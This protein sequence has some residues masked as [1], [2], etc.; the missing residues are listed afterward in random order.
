MAQRY[1]K[2][3]YPLAKTH[4]ANVTKSGITSN[5]KGLWWRAIYQSQT[6]C[7]GANGMSGRS[8]KRHYY[9]TPLN[10]WFSA[11][12]NFNPNR[13]TDVPELSEAYKN[14]FTFNKSRMGESR[15]SKHIQ[16]ILSVF[17]KWFVIKTL[18]IPEKLHECLRFAAQRNKQVA[19]TC[20]CFFLR[21][22][23]ILSH[24]KSKESAAYNRERNN[25][26]RTIGF[27][28]IIVRGQ[29]E[30]SS[31]VKNNKQVYCVSGERTHITKSCGLKIDEMD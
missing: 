10:P 13:K 11:G 29:Q 19:S 15:S 3:P 23:W 20:C 2:R 30:Q 8:K 6:I 1:E 22:K 9:T 25:L 28:G 7:I 16:Y 5:E 21:R 27:T 31:K 4:R 18:S 17:K 12:E 14:F 26:L 24:C